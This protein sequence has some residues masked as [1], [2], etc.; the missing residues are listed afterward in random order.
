MIIS[1]ALASGHISARAWAYAVRIYCVKVVPHA[2]WRGNAT[3]WLHRQPSLPPSIDGLITDL[4]SLLYFWYTVFYKRNVER[5]R[6]A[7]CSYPV[8]ARADCFGSWKI[9][10]TLSCVLTSDSVL[11]VELPILRFTER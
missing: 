10:Y 4:I 5:E 2:L 8:R 1:R 7:R 9:H 11:L 6:L 3:L